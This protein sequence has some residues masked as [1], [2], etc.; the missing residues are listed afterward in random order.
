M[1][2]VSY[3]LGM[4][5]NTSGRDVLDYQGGGRDWLAYDDGRR[6]LPAGIPDRRLIR[7][8]IYTPD[9]G[10]SRQQ[11]E[12]FGE[13]FE[14]Q[15][16]PNAATAVPNNQWSALFGNRWGRFGL[17]GSF[18][19]R[20]RP[21]RREE[22]QKYYRREGT[23]L[24]TFS[25]YTYRAYDVTSSWAGVLNAGYMANPS[26]KLSF[27]GFSTN[28]GTRETRQFE[29]FNA[30]V[31]ENLRNTR[32][33][34]TEENL[35]TGQVSGDH[36]FAGL[37]NSRLEWRASAAR[38]NRDE[39]DLRE[40]LYQE[41]GG[42]YVLA[43]ESQSGFRMF[44]DLDENVYDL[45]ANWA[46][47]FTTWAGL[48]AQVKLGPQFSRR[49]RDFSSRRFR[50]IPQSTSGVNLAASAEEIFG[51]E[52][53]GPKFEL[54]EE[55]RATDFYGARQDIAA[56]YGMIDLPLASAWRIIGGVRVERFDQRV[57]TFDLFDTDVDD[58]R[59]VIGARIEETDVFP[60]VNL[61]WA[62]RRDQNLRLGVSQT[63]NRPEFR[64][65]APFEF[66][67][68]VG[69]RAVAGNPDL[70]RSLI[71]NYDMRWEWFPGGDQVVAASLFYKRF[72][73]PIE[74]FVEPT[75]QLRT[76]FQNAESA[77]NLG[78]ELEARKRITPRFMVGANYTYVDSSIALSPSQTNVL[79]TLERPLAG[80]SENLFN[81]F[82]EGR[83]G[84]LTARVLLNYFDDRII[85]VGSLGLPDIME[86]GRTTVDAVAHL[87][88]PRFTLRFSADNLTDERIEYTQGG[89]LQ[90]AYK[91]GR[92]LSVQL[93][94]NAF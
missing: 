70:T 15:W 93:G 61:V 45:S 40:T 39:P 34:W 52:N 60:S 55:T 2:S 88:L 1:L 38:S 67:D 76:S 91:Y 36:L 9:L 26:H 89:L 47:V 22:V 73:D 86:T 27:Q 75:A 72:N 31:G 62:A 69:G 80:T 42:T 51:P 5:S 13:A 49:E 68:I 66:T 37:S 53:I 81:G 74:R 41:I 33:M 77:R 57:D 19:Q 78:L 65:L 79:T 46:T 85:D 10:F 84:R 90:R 14:N 32:L 20:Q 16:T 21:Q 18:N 58:Q 87:R 94:F 8:G 56:L 25:D 64:E 28:S 7:G 48:P 12:S 54:R 6:S 17:S 59:D 92:T 30:D 83:A 23:G 43:D 11:L 82:V 3:E 50:F 35:R 4:N 63:V 24:S 71:Q 44:S 29:G